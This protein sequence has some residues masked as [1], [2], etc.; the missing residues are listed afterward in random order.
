MWRNVV[1]EIPTNVSEEHDLPSFHSRGVSIL[2]IKAE[3]SSKTLVNVS[4]ATRRHVPEDN[5][6]HSHRN[7]N[8]RLFLGTPSPSIL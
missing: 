5:N 6:V 8:L 4:H 1:W 2:K 7:Q 3:Y